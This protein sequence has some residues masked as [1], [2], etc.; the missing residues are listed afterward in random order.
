LLWRE[1]TF[2]L[3]RQ[4]RQS[5]IGTE[6]R[7]STPRWRVVVPFMIMGALIVVFSV[8]RF[9]ETSHVYPLFLSS[10]SANRIINVSANGENTTGF[11]K[12]KLVIP[13]SVKVDDPFVLELRIERSEKNTNAPS[14]TEYLLSSVGLQVEPEKQ[15]LRPLFQS[16]TGI[17]R[18]SAKATS[19]G[20]YLVIVNIRLAEEEAQK[21]RESKR[22]FL[23]R[24]LKNTATSEDM[25]KQIRKEI[26]RPIPLESPDFL[27]PIQPMKVNV[28]GTIDY[29]A[30]KAIPYLGTFLGSLLTLPGLFAFR[31]AHEQKRKEKMRISVASEIPN[32]IQMP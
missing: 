2:L 8:K 3:L 13:S 9:L 23:E 21:E 1:D 15:W 28:S 29:Y 20:K 17:I 25:Q 10:Y 6:K 19:M 24:L 4:S 5:A 16:Q 26:A 11:P 22:V 31:D 18:W 7:I 14:V 30:A 27:D 32:R 12:I